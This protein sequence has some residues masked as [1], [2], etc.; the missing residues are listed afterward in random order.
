MAAHPVRSRAGRGGDAP[1]G[2]GRGMVF[3]WLIV[4]YLFLAG[5][6]AGAFAVA[7][8]ACVWDAWRPTA[9]SAAVVRAVQPGLA[10]APVLVIVSALLLLADL[11]SLDAAFRVLLQP[12]RTVMAAGAWLVAALAAC[13]AAVAA[14]GVMPRLAWAPAAWALTLA[15]LVAAL[16]VM[17]YSGLLLSDAVAVDFWR[18]PWLT[19]LFVASSLSGGTALVVGAGLLAAP[20][21]MANQAREDAVSALWRLGGVLACVELA[22]L[23][24]FLVT[25]GLST[26]SARASCQLLLAGPLSIPFWGGVVGAGIVAPLALHGAVRGR[27]AGRA[28]AMAA[29]ACGV[30]VGGAALRLCVV[31]GAVMA[32]LALT[33][34]T[35]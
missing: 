25:R 15:G 17:A 31:A 34:V 29:S 27:G 22:V 12:P 35:I 24:V 33:A 10:L 18:T 16:G 11:G 21:G 1:R 19:A 28:A 9:A 23:A 6:G 8:G 5:T 20:P 26:E 4:G 32:P 13:G 7:A 30:L 2:K 3:S 14:M